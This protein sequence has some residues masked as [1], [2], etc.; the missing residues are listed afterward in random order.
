M[1]TLVGH[2]TIDESTR[3]AHDHWP[4]SLEHS[5]QPHGHRRNGT[6]PASPDPG[7]VPSILWSNRAVQEAC[8]MRYFVEELAPWVRGSSDRPRHDVS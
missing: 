8:L 3:E 6:A 5:E 7:R 2:P 4:G 1:L